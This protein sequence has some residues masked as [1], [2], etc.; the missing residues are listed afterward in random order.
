LRLSGAASEREQHTP[1]AY[2]GVVDFEAA[3]AETL[4]LA[5]SL[6]YDEAA[7]KARELVVRLIG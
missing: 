5:R 6:D 4:N 7:E 2:G 1:T 3:L